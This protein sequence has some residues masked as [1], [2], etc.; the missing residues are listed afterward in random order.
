M[1]ASKAAKMRHQSPMSIDQSVLLDE[2]NRKLF[3]TQKRSVS[4]GKPEDF[5]PE[6]ALSK[7]ILNPVR[8]LRGKVDRPQR[9]SE[10]V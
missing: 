9:L 2:S 8:K 7:S 1:I 6:V 10:S 4:K 5:Y 3:E